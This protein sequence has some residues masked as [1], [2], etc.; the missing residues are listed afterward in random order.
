MLHDLHVEHGIELLTAGREGFGGGQPIVQVQTTPLGVEFGYPD[1]FGRDID[2]RD[3]RAEA[4]QGLAQDS[5]A[6][7]DVQQPQARQG[8]RGGWIGA[9]GVAKMLA[10]VADAEGVEPV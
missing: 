7:A 4:C 2:T 5:T 10:K 1:I 3:A 9:E 8:K 6:A